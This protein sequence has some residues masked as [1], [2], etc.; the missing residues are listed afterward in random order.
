MINV[1]M[2]E[3]DRKRSEPVEREDAVGGETHQ[4][5]ERILGFSGSPILAFVLQSAF[6]EIMMHETINGTAASA[7]TPNSHLLR[8]DD[9]R[10]APIS[11]T[12]K[13]PLET[14]F[15]GCHGFNCKIAFHKNALQ[16]HPSSSL[17]PRG[18]G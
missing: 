6:A 10:S 7:G 3:I 4:L 17:R 13:V 18:L 15:I 12:C 9:F 5:P 16:S 11:T 1:A 2:P 8:L 14:R